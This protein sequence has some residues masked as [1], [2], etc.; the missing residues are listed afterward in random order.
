MNPKI[1]DFIENETQTEYKIADLLKNA[2]YD[3]SECDELQEY[4]NLFDWDAS[5]EIQYTWNPECSTSGTLEYSSYEEVME[6]WGN[7]YEPDQTEI[8][9]NEPIEYMGSVE[10]DAV[11][12]IVSDISI[13][14]DIT[15]DMKI[16]IHKIAEEKK[17]S[18][19]M[20]R[21]EIEVWGFIR[22]GVDIEDIY[23]IVAKKRSEMMFGS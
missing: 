14:G 15:D 3:G 16:L 17:I 13:K 12:V 6:N 11:E 2:I 21:F 1:K 10:Q 19:L 23:N 20:K 7:A 22:D 8:C 5:Y 4:R 9:W 18:K